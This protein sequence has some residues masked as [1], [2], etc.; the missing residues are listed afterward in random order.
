MYS[1][2]NLRLYFFISLLFPIFK[3]QLLV[4]A[5]FSAKR[6]LQLFQLEGR[7][8]RWH[9]NSSNFG[10]NI[11]RISGRKSNWLRLKSNVCMYKKKRNRADKYT[12]T[13]EKCSGPHLQSYPACKTS[14]VD[15]IPVEML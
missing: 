3:R 9:R 11:N 4:L 2:F 6:L 8:R 1:V 14:A 13:S 10:R 5:F 12:K 15:K 7:R